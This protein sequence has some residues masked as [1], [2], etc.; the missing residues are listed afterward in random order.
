MTAP[1]TV[2]VEPG[3]GPNC[4]STFTVSFY[5]GEKYR[6]NPPKPSNP[7]VYLDKLP[8]MTVYAR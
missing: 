3:A 2:R 4:E 1:V 8:E 6:Q 5:I 7:E